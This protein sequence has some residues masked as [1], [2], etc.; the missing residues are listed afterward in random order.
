V[1][2]GGTREVS[3]SPRVGS[4]GFLGTKRGGWGGRVDREGDPDWVK[5]RG[6]CA[7]AG[8]EVDI[9]VVQTQNRYWR[10]GGGEGRQRARRKKNARGDCAAEGDRGD[11]E[12]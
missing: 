11:T 9:P 3:A 7:V 1:V 6:G 2:V 8:E 5:G 4:E 12:T 10:P